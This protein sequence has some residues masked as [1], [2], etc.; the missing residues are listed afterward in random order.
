MSAIY[1]PTCSPR[2]AAAKARLK[3]LNS[4]EAGESFE[5]RPPF[6]WRTVRSG[7]LALLPHSPCSLGGSSGKHGLFIT[8]LLPE[9]DDLN[10]ANSHAGGATERHHFRDCHHLEPLAPPTILPSCQQSQ[11]WGR[12]GHSPCHCGDAGFECLRASLNIFPQFSTYFCIPIQAK[13]N[14]LLDAIPMPF[15][16]TASFFKF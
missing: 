16:C 14:L 5:L 1:S 13:E 6:F 8:A 9:L 12:E 7:G 4:R 2:F 11:G 15:R 3:L 10:S